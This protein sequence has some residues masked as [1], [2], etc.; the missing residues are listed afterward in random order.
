MI[1]GTVGFLIFGALSDRIGRKPIIL[2][3]CLIAAITII[4]VFKMLTQLGNPALS[5]AQQTVVTVVADPA[6]CSFQFNPTGTVKFTNSCDV[7][8]AQLARTS[9][10][11]TTVDGAAGAVAEIKVGETVIKS[12]DTVPMLLTSRPQPKPSKR[13]R[14]ALT[15]L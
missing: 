6:N 11:Y 8:K 2:A 1:I 13:P 14:L 12:Y 5:A 4:P 9:V 3:G 15:R 10:N 7:A